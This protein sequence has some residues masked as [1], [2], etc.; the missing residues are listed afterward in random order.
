MDQRIIAPLDGKKAKGVTEAIVK[1]LKPIK[2][3]VHTI[4]DGKK[5]SYH[6]FIAKSLDCNAY[7]AMPYHTWERGQN[8]NV[9][10]PLRQ[11]FSKAM[12]FSM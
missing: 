4:D 12:G 1:L 7:F 11:Y 9:N 3:L 6:E 5:F 10:G 8:E 2:E